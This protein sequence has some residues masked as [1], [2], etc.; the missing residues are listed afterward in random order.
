MNTKQNIVK[1]TAQRAILALK[2]QLYKNTKQ[3][4]SKEDAFIIEG[5]YQQALDLKEFSD[6]MQK[7]QR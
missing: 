3:T 5:L 6:F 1:E 7:V 2:R 4:I